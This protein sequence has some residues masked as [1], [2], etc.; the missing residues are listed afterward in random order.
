VSEQGRPIPISYHFDFTGVEDF[1]EYR[2]DVNGIPQVY[3]GRS[4]GWQYN[5]ITVAQ[6]G[7]A[8]LTAWESS[9]QDEELA[10]ARGA[11]RW[12]VEHCEEHRRQV[13]AW[14]YR[15]D[16]PFYGPKAPWISAMAQGE[17]ISLL[18]RLWLLDAQEE[19][20]QVARK[21]IR[22]FLLPTEKGGVLSSFPDGRPVFEEFPTVPPPHVLNGHIFALLGVYDFWKVT[23]EQGAGELFSGAVQ[24]LKE[25]LWRYDLGWWTLYD[26]HPTRRLASRAYQRIHMRLMHVLYR[27]TG[28]DVFAQ[29]E[30]R[31]RGYLASPVSAARWAAAKVVEKARLRRYHG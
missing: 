2:F 15:F 1:H 19:Y 23:G 5:A 22:A 4:I 28:D 12:L 16:L 30:A 25:N 14:I 10:R 31:W 20:L 27:L 13:G 6:Y 9:G 17:A 7:L 29:W 24:G 18:L 11:G 3:Y 26:L 8:R 21:A